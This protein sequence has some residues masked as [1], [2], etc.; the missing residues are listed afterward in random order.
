VKI[1]APIA[2][3]SSAQLEYDLHAN[4]VLLLA[5]RYIVHMFFFKKKAQA[6]ST[7]PSS[8]ACD[9]ASWVTVT[10]EGSAMNLI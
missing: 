8:H 2:P 7:P 4:S 3:M 1:T 10:G 5:L 6:D 9:Q